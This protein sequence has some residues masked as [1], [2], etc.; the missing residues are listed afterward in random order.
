MG[1]KSGIRVI[2]EKLTGRKIV[3][4]HPF[5]VSPLN[6]LV[7]RFPNYPFE[8]IFDVG[9]NI[10][11]SA[12]PFSTRFPK[13]RIYCFEP[14]AR[15][16]ATLSQN[17][18]HCKN[19]ESYQ[20]ALGATR[21]EKVITSMKNSDMSTLK[22]GSDT[23]MLASG[24]ARTEIIKVDTIS[25]FCGRHHIK[26]ISYLKIDTE[27]YDLEVIK[28][29]KEMLDRSEIDFVEL[30]A[31]MN[32]KNK[33]HVPLEEIKEY[34]EN[35]GYS[36]FGIYEQVQEWITQKPILRRSNLLFISDKMANR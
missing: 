7:F 12:V 4:R 20:M 21:S 13:S 15:T 2:I 9:A 10:G 17:L 33:L 22:A 24:E 34:M 35:H 25:E 29:G 3:K 18:R 27:G 31:G 6:D 11:Q 26:R 8:V 1:I 16:F 19:V 36:L 5:G 14:I 30:E 32:P 23:D 28:G